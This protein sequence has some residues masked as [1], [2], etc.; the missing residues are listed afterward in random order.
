MDAEL[1][2]PAGRRAELGANLQADLRKLHRQAIKQS[3]SVRASK[4]KLYRQ[5]QVR[6]NYI[7]KKML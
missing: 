7:V 4:A 1:A 3:Y 6:Q 5:A 2:I